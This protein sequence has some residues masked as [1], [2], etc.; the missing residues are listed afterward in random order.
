[1]PRLIVRLNITSDAYLRHYRG[2]ARDVVAT[3]DDGLRVR[4]P[5]N[6]L[7]TVVTRDGVRGRFVIEFDD[8]GKFM[9][10]EGA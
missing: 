3:T 4:F 2:S 1:M 6:V 5:A 8:Q 10:I 7:R 9:S